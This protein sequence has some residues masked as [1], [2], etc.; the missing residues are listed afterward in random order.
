MVTSPTTVHPCVYGSQGRLRSS[1]SSPP[2]VGPVRGR[3]LVSI[4][5]GDA[6][7]EG[8]VEDDPANPEGSGSW[9]GGGP[10]GHA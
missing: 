6:H 8:G 10:P 5:W 1:S 4:E 3:H 2:H 7:G 9:S